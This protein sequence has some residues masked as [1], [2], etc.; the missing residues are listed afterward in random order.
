MDWSFSDFVDAA[1][2]L[3]TSGAEVYNAWKGD[4]SAQDEETAYLKGQLA[5]MEA[6]QKSQ[7]EADTI[8]IGDASI[9]TASLLWVIG[10]TLGLLAIGLGLKKL[11]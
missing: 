1:K 11:V 6:S 3:G 4:T 10:G 7:L 5:A 2:K 9:S 8:R